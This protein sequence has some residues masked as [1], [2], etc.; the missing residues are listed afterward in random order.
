M[1]QDNTNTLQFVRRAGQVKR[2]HSE[3]VIK[4]QTVGEH[5]FNVVWLAYLLTDQCPSVGLLM[6]CMAHDAAEHS[7]GDIP[8]PTKRL[9][10]IRD[11]VDHLEAKLMSG[12]GLRLPPMDT[13][14][15]FILKLA[16]AMD[17]LLY[18]LR[19]RSL[20]NRTL[21]AVWHNYWNYCLEVLATYHADFHGVEGAALRTTYEVADK[22]LKDAGE[23]WEQMQ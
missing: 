6:G 23:Q 8:S 11:L 16:D 2:Y 5:T 3:L 19:E 12:A 15:L 13:Y 21:G 18:V 1:T 14:D 4:E 9:L 7:T 17:G 20:G 10:D 22:I